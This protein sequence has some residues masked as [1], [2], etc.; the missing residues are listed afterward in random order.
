MMNQER[1]VSEIKTKIYYLVS[2]ENEEKMDDTKKRQ[3]EKNKWTCRNE[4]RCIQQMEGGD[5]EEGVGNTNG[6]NLRW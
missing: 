4:W 1:Q 6:I 2:Y 5:V 3:E